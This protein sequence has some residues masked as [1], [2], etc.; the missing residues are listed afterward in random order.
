[1]GRP[2]EELWHSSFA[3]VTKMIDMYADEMKMKAAAL[4]NQ[5]YTSKY[6]SEQPEVK[7]V[8][9]LKEIPGF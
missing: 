2:E 3:K 5:P 7:E 6:F 8:K 9:S 4:N 1:M